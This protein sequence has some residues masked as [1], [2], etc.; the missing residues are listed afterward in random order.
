MVRRGV[1]DG[2]TLVPLTPDSDVPRIA[3]ELVQ[4]G[5]ATQAI[6]GISVPSR[7]DANGATVLGVTDGGPAAQA[8]IPTGAVVTKVDDRGSAR[9]ESPRGTPEPLL[10]MSTSSGPGMTAPRGPIWR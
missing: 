3:D 8:G 1:A 10:A 5:K 7:D 4:S 9:T 6:I 2:V